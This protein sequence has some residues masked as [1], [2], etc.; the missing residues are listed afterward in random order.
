VVTLIWRDWVELVF[1]VSPDNGNGSFEWFLFA[2][3]LVATFTF[4]ILARYEW[5]RARASTT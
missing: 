2:V 5:R 1:H 3:L 4:S